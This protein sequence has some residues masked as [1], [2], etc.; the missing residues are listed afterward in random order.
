MGDREHT[1]QPREDRRPVDVGAVPGEEDVSRAQTADELDETPD[2]QPNRTD[3]ADFDP[4]E[5]RQ[6]DDPP[7]ES[8]GPYERSIA[9]ADHPEDR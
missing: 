4:D 1:T 7:V 8:A 2:G 5:R 6:Y 9:D 3:Q